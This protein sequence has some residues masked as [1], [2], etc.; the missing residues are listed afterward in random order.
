MDASAASKGHLWAL[1]SV[2]RIK[3][4]RSR[5][6]ATPML[7]RRRQRGGRMGADPLCA[8]D[9]LRAAWVTR[10]ESV[11]P[12]ER[13]AGRSNSTPFFTDDDGDEA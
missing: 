10:E 13:T 4:Q 7:V 9:A 6:K 8:Y 3:D 5:L 12:E 1:V 11:P 2:V